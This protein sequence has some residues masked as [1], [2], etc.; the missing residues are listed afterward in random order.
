MSVEVSKQLAANVCS[1]T[2]TQVLSVGSKDLYWLSRLASV[3]HILN[4]I[5]AMLGI[6]ARA[7]SILITLPVE[8]Y[9][10]LLL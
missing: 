3:T 4:P 6:E 8:L 7:S 10:P 9:P 5:C 2:R 1:G